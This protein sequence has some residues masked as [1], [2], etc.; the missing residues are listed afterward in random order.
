MHYPLTDIQADFGVNRPIRYQVTAK[1]NY[2]H[3]Q[4]DGT[5]DGWTD[6]RTDRQIDAAYDNNRYFFFKKEKTT[7]NCCKKY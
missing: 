3:R 5:T 6:R 7:K 4:T 2:L 1:G